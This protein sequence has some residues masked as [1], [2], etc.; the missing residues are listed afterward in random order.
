MRRALE[1]Y[2]W[3]AWCVMRREGVVALASRVRRR[4]SSTAVRVRQ[5]PA[6]IQL[7]D[8]AALP[9]FD[10]QAAPEA[11]IIIPVHGQLRYTRHCLTALA[12]C[13]TRRSFEVIVVDDASPDETSAVLASCSGL[14]LLT[15]EQNLGFVKAC[16][17]GAECARGEVLV[18]L[19]NDTQVQPGWLDALLETFQSSADVGVVGSKLI[20]PHGRLQEAGGIVFND[21]T[22]WNYGHLDEPGRPQYSYLREPDYVS[23]ASLAIRRELFRVLGGFDEAY[24]PGYYEDVDLAFR[25]RAAGYRLCYQPLSQVVH[26]EGVTGGLRDSDDASGMKRFQS[27]NRGTFVARWHQELAAHGSR[28]ADL[29]RQK[30]RTLRRRVLVVDAYILTPDRESGSLRMLRLLQIL[31]ELGYRATFAAANLQCVEPYLS[32]L[33]RQGI[34][35]LCRPHVRSLRAYLRSEGARF[36]LLILSRADAAAKV[37]PTA[38]R[39][40]PRAFIV[41]DTV[42]LHFLREERLAELSQSRADRIQARLRREQELALIAEADATL[43]VSPIERQRIAE[44]APSARIEVVSN[45]H[46]V[47]GSRRPF[48][49]RRGIMFIGTFAHPPNLDGILWFAHEILPR[50]LQVDPSLELV[51]IGADPPAEV[52]R[53]ASANVRVVGQVPDVEPYLDGCRLSV[54]PLRYGAGVK[55][56]V[57]QSLAYGLPVVATNVAA[58]GAQLHHGDSAL[59]ADEPQD[60]ASA[61]NRLNQ[62]PQLWERLSLGGQAVIESHFSVAAARRGLEALLAQHPARGQRRP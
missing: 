35:V 42:D 4:L 56:K 12:A 45:I 43:V 7:G 61:V 32:H 17:R 10:E 46:P 29:E 59:I 14:R 28:A 5:R 51:I 44:L 39:Y 11:S 54:A 37:M 50:C 60:F 6:L 57:N 24:S 13:Q 30:E 21:G 2:L 27:I 20:F 15:L 26:F 38:R 62:D 53:L 19:N 52:R 31:R 18:F 58:E 55:G 25:V 22:C 36:D 23:G 3:R 9:A 33:Q 16:N 48:A 49:E 34:E 41:F 1:L 8:R 47:I 40:C